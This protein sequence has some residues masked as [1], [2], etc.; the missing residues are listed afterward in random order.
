VWEQQ[1][2]ACARLHRVLVQLTHIV[3]VVV[4]IIILILILI[5]IIIVIIARI[6]SLLFCL[7]KVE[8]GGAAREA[9]V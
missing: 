5:I 6:L 7:R 8:A 2:H 4:T 9:L 1:C 3:V